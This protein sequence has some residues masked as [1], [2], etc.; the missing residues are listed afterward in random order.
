MIFL[1]R[2]IFIHFTA[3]DEDEPTEPS[4]YIESFTK[5]LKD[6]YS[7]HDKVQPTFECFLMKVSIFGL[8]MLYFWLCDGLRI[9]LVKLIIF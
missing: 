3:T 2:C 7:S 8:F 6:I 5:K 4:S 1:K 9:W